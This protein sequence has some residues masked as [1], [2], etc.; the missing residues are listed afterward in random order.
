MLLYDRKTDSL[1]SQVK[2]EA[3]TGPLTGTKLRSIPSVVTT[4]KRWK[5]LHPNTLVLSTKTGYRRDYSRDP[6]KFY[7]NSPLAFLG[8]KGKRDKRLPEKEL[9]LGIVAESE[10]KAYPFSVL[11]GLKSPVID[12]ISG[13]KIKIHF[14]KT[15]EEAYATLNDGTRLTGMV[16]Y[17]FVWSSFHPDSTVFRPR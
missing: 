13:Q 14:D 15:S 9:V 2:S 17:W 8:F 16:S 3:V 11:K 10:K 6:Y 12:T 5:T 1:W 7:F 4:W